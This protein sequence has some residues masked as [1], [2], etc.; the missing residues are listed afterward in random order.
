M[1]TA[2]RILRQEQEPI[3]LMLDLAD[4]VLREIERGGRVAPE[5]LAGL[6]EFFRL[7][8]ERFHNRKEED[9]LFPLL[10]QKGVPR[11]GGCIGVMLAEHEQGRTLIRQMTAAADAYGEGDAEAVISWA[12]AGR[13]YTTLL[14][15]HIHREGHALYSMAESLLSEAEQN[16]LVE[17]FTKLEEKE[18]SSGNKHRVHA[19][20]DLLTR[21]APQP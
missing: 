15:Q 5:T 21:R 7:F 6:S 20:M 19:L 4:E 18:T 17:A 11:K 1:G 14:R 10:E 16:E 13:N 8:A 12:E 9:L 3:L 2:T